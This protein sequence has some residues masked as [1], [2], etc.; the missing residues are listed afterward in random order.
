MNKIMI[1]ASGADVRKLQRLL[2]IADD[3]IFG[4]LTKEAVMDF[5]KSNCLVVDGIVG[6]KTWEVLLATPGRSARRIDEVI[7]HCSATAEGKD[8]HASDIKRWHTL[9]V[10][11]GGRGWSD[12]GYHYVITLSGKIEAGRDIDIAGA[13]CSGHNTRS[14]GICYVGGCAKDGKTP[15]DTRTDSQKESLYQLLTSIKH[16]YPNVKIHGHKDFAAKACP[17]YDATKE[18][19]NI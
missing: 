2:N 9:P 14:I 11:K 12:I 1:G 17:S 7:I 5:Q 6:A 15:K 3:G 13:H 10:S 16:L 19:K 8:Y 18:Y 4:E